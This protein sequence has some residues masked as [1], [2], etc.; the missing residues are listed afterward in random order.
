LNQALL[1]LHPK[2][3]PN[4]TEKYNVAQHSPHKENNLNNYIEDCIRNDDE[5]YV[6][7]KCSSEISEYP[8]SREERS[9][10]IHSSIR[11]VITQIEGKATKREEFESIEQT[12][13]F[14][15]RFVL[16]GAP[17]SGKTTTLKY[18]V[19]FLARN[20]KDN[21]EP[22]N[23]PLFIDLSDWPSH[24]KDFRS[25]INF[26]K[27]CKGISNL[28]IDRLLL[29]IDGLDEVDDEKFE[30]INYYLTSNPSIPTIIASRRDHYVKKYNLHIPEVKIEPLEDQRIKNFIKK[31]AGKKASKLLNFLYQ[32]TM[33]S[34]D[35]SRLLLLAGN[36]YILT[37]ICE[38]FRSNKDIPSQRG[39][40]FK[41]LV[42]ALHNRE[43]K[44]GNVHGID[45]DLV[46]KAYAL[47]AFKMIRQKISYSET[48][49]WFEKQLSSIDIH[50]PIDIFELGISADLIIRYKRKDS[51]HFR[52][53]H[54]LLQDYFAAEYIHSHFGKVSKYLTTPIIENQNRRKIP[55][56]SAIILLLEF[57]ES[58]NYLSE[59]LDKDPFLAAEI[60]S[61][62]KENINDDIRITLAHKMIK[63]L[64]RDNLSVKD[65]AVNIL[66]Q[67]NELSI[68]PLSILLNCEEHWKRRRALEVLSQTRSL[69]SIQYVISALNDPNRWVRRDAARIISF[70]DQEIKNLL[71]AYI[72]EKLIQKEEKERRIT[73]ESLVR[74][75]D[76]DDLELSQ[77]LFNV[78]G[79]EFSFD[80]IEENIEEEK[81]CVA[82]ETEEKVE[83]AEWDAIFEDM[84]LNS[85]SD[86]LI[87]QRARKWLWGAPIEHKSWSFAWKT[88]W[89]ENKKDPDLESIALYWLSEALV[90]HR[91]WAHVW[92]ALWEEKTESEELFQIGRQWL[93]TV[94]INHAGW[95]FVWLA[96]WEKNPGDSNLK[97]IGI[98]YVRKTN[99]EN[100]SLGFV[101]LSLLKNAPN[102]EEIK[103]IGRSWLESAPLDNPLWGYAFPALW[104]SKIRDQDMLN[105]GYLWLERA[106]V[107]L[108]A[109][110]YIWPALWEA[111]PGKIELEKFGRMWVEKASLDHGAWGYIFLELLGNSPHDK[112]LRNRGIKYL[113]GT[114]N[115]H[116]SWA[117][118]WEA[119]WKTKLDVEEL[120]VLGFTWIEEVSIEHSGWSY[121]WWY[122]WERQFKKEAL[123]KIGLRWIQNVQHD[124]GGWG[125]IFP[126]IYKTD[127][128]TK[129]EKI[130]MNW[131]EEAD[132][133]FHGWSW[134][135]ESLWQKTTQKLDLID[136]GMKWLREVKPEDGSWSHVWCWLWEDNPNDTEINEKALAWLKTVKV[137]HKSWNVVWQHLWDRNPGEDELITLACKWLE[138]VNLRRE[139]WFHVW[140]N[141]K[142][143]LPDHPEIM[144]ASIR[145]LRVPNISEQH[146]ET[147]FKSI[148]SHPNLPVDIKMIRNKKHRASALKNGESS[149]REKL[150]WLKGDSSHEKQWPFRWV[151]LYDGTDNKTELVEIGAEWLASHSGK[152]AGWALV[153]SRIIS[154]SEG[155]N[156]LIDRGWEWMKGDFDKRSSW[157]LVWKTLWNF[158]SDSD[159][160]NKL[161]ELAIK[162]IRR[163]GP[164]KK[165]AAIV[166]LTLWPFQQK[167]EE[168]LGWGINFLE[169]MDNHKDGVE[170]AES[171]C[172]S[173]NVQD[174]VRSKLLDWLK[175]NSSNEN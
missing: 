132:L 74:Y 120:Q 155:E 10:F 138:K 170:I 121:V 111:N 75:F 153:W 44:K 167:N 45:Y 25:L 86:Y 124:H 56:Y 27:E 102:N 162:W 135:W 109:W 79:V 51:D 131:L 159:S 118:V 7:L 96:L 129:I 65:K 91:G 19:F 127:P 97:Y 115:E 174:S 18:F 33:D 105:L 90:D 93:N 130:G 28:S 6:R 95:G 35:K 122:L 125:H 126:C 151:S 80:K 42:K 161:S 2:Y 88:L 66:V 104:D 163:Q 113:N 98:D 8:S 31:Y 110:G 64:E 61:D 134:V 117:L 107:D 36:P 15:R 59:I 142:H 20:V 54:R 141:F 22:S 99:V 70:P 50:K 53:K 5:Y 119:L 30:Q 77:K 4:D 9:K 172:E 92:I 164:A 143:L 133:N 13:K 72:D 73:G 169:K 175:T 34:D 160:K 158:D 43:N 29:L 46:I 83:Y 116:G 37:C 11:D 101:W 148:A 23:I 87:A 12:L 38:L 154:I 123:F 157:P 168:L 47:I 62:L 32:E 1:E 137:N 103:T 3:H 68:Q 17:G 146:W 108:G 58:E 136:L 60:I 71:I 67:L 156:K 173:S 166:W 89:Q 78:T 171:I 81:H 165:D 152:K 52:F 100:E 147:V 145:C 16:L 106:S 48:F 85:C 144:S 82:D 21:K 76:S 55:L 140:K 39:K 26:E 139:Y 49:N 84:Q 69:N 114:P 149:E 63:F 40:L 150:N 94:S 57:E 14:H 128:N 41:F 112:D 24:I